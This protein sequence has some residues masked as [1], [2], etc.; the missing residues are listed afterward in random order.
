MKL[1]HV[2]AGQRV[3]RSAAPPSV[4]PDHETR[5]F[6]RGIEKRLDI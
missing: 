4:D 6:V 1:P 3:H 2:V 5:D